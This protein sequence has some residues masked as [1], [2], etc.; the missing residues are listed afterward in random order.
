[1]GSS[2]SSLYVPLK[3]YKCL[4]IHI[5]LINMRNLDT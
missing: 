5:L 3:W 2:R 1:V 4:I